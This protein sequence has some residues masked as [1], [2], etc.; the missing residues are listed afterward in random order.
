MAKVENIS[1]A[2]SF[3]ISYTELEKEAEKKMGAGGFGYVQSGAGGEETLRKNTES[4][5][6]YSIVPRMLRDVSVPDT[7]VTLFGKTYPYP[8]FLAPIGMQRLE[9]EEG[10]IA[11]SRAAAVYHVPF[12]QSTVSSYSIEEIA[13]A[14][15]S[16]P[17]WFQLYWSNHEETAFNMVRR[18]EEAGYEAIVLTVDTVMMGWREADLRN[19]F[20]PL[21]LGYGKAN[22]ESDPVF[23]SSLKDG[24]VVQGILD[25]IHHPTLS[26]EHV[27]RLKEKTNL[28]ILLKGI[29]HPE[30]A[31][32][33]VDKG[34]DGIIVSNH[35]GRQLDGV[36]AAIDALEPIAK[37]VNGR[38]PVLFDSGIRRGSDA[39]KALALGAD[40]VC[41]GRPYVYGLAIGGQAGVEKVLANFIEETRVSL[42]LAGVSSLKEIAGLK[43]IR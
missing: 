1:F 26:W 43:L 36:T 22:Y 31:K 8:I 18:A 11:S 25:N 33:A 5:A 3:P 17:K 4:F 37:A 14:T 6:K 39:V 10:E 13:A 30:D 28:P 16:S 34:L 19:N 24:D 2:E 7:S 21:K 41:L 12:I 42:S 32:L 38:I 9:H 20:S 27:A 29:L 40:A 35:G 23:M 15:G